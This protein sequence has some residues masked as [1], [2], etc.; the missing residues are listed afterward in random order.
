[1]WSSAHILLRE[2]GKIF[3]G[4]TADSEEEQE[5]LLQIPV[6]VMKKFGNGDYLLP[7][8][9]RSG[10]HRSGR[11]QEKDPRLFLLP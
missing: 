1:V 2:D 9:D 11:G 3:S 5:E 10:A 4:R 6:D 7:T 8:I